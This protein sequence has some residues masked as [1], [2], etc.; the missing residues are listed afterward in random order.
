MS[1]VHRVDPDDPRFLEPQVVVGALTVNTD[2]ML[3]ARSVLADLSTGIGGVWRTLEHARHAAEAMSAERPATAASVMAFIDQADAQSRAVIATLNDMRQAMESSAEYYA[4]ADSEACS[5]GVGASSA[6]GLAGAVGKLSGF[7]TRG[8]Y[9][10]V[11]VDEAGNRAFTANQW[12]AAQPQDHTAERV[13]ATAAALGGASHE[14]DVPDGARPSAD[15]LRSLDGISRDEDAG[16][17]VIEEHVSIVDGEEVRSWTVVL[18]GTQNWDPVSRN[19]Q[20]LQTN[21][22]AVGGLASEQLDAVKTAMEMAGIGQGEP[23]E[24]VGHSQGGIIAAQLACD[25]AFASKYAI[26][27]VTTAGS[28]IAGY[29]PRGTPVLALEND[30]DI[31]PG[32]DLS[33]NQLTENVTTA[34]Y[35]DAAYDRQLGIERSSAH[36]ASGYGDQLEYSLNNGESAQG[37]IASY[38]ERRNRALGLNDT[39]RTTV[40][41]Y[42]TRRVFE[43]PKEVPPIL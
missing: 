32:L 28:P 6:R 41:S 21:L 5:R 4:A 23:V 3:A 35:H 37:P 22:Q 16:R 19:P 18:Q 1:P 24:L 42:A 2:D 34:T 36:D 38:E 33:P 7:A 10:V 43:P 26:T 39:T 20:D 13:A 30:R 12:G 25:A 27:N 11:V 8:N 15:V 17:V 40:H 29:A 14:Y 9:G 31:V